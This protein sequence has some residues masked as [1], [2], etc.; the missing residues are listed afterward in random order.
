[1]CTAYVIFS[2]IIEKVKN[3]SCSRDGI[4]ICPYID[5]QI[6]D[7]IHITRNNIMNMNMTIIY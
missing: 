7:T 1:M 3:V 5:K 4:G 6:N 2:F